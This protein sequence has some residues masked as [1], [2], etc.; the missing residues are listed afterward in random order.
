M[1][2][3]ATLLLD[4]SARSPTESLPTGSDIAK[5]A[6]WFADHQP[7]LT[8]NDCSGLMEAVLSR[9]GLPMAG[10]TR[11][12]W[13]WALDEHRVHKRR[14]PLPGDLV[15]FDRTWDRNGNGRTDDELTHIA[16]VT[17]VLRFRC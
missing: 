4:A 13:E 11:S 7:Q 1:I 17:A 6:K 9:A 8:R 14:V 10:S 3:L 2:L 12:F 5:A 16:V 15:F